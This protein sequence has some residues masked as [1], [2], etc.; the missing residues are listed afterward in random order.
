M[1][2]SKSQYIKGL[3]CNKALWLLKNKPQLKTPFPEQTQQNFNI[4]YQVG[5]LA[6]E[7]FPSGVEIEFNAKDF[8]QMISKTKQLINENLI[9]DGEEIIYEA[10][11]SEKGVFVMVD[12]LRKNGD[13]WD[14]YEVKASTRVK[15]I[16]LEDIAVQKYALVEL[17]NI[18]NC[19]VVH[20]NS[21]YKRQGELDIE[22]LFTIENVSEEIKSIK[23]VKNELEKIQLML[24]ND[25]PNIDIGSHCFSPYACEFM[26]NCWQDI[27]YPSVFN[28][29][30][31]GAKKFTHYQNNKIAYKD[32][33]AEKLTKIQNIQIDTYLN[34]KTHIDKNIIQEF[35]DEVVYPIN[36]FDFETF[37]NA[38]P[39][40]DNQNPYQ[41]IPFQY[42]LH[43][44][45]KD[46][47]L[48]HK[49]FLGSEFED[50]R[51]DLIKNMLKD[52]TKKGSIIAYNQSFEIGRIKDLAEFNPKNK[53]ELLALNPR[54]LD[55]IVPF[56]QLGYYH[57]DFHGSFSIK[58]VLPAMFPNDDELDYKKLD[59]QDGSMAM[60]TFA[61]LY[62]VKDKS[63]RLTIKKNLLAYCRLDTLAM[64]RIYQK[65]L[66]F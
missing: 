26:D 34:N 48:E 60:D 46:G 47:K 17:L 12:I 43:I 59:I 35:V 8:P 55:L 39:R 65:L 14:I 64:V 58:S 53:K 33:Q 19:F 28:L 52:I 36:F 45:H 25:E 23:E 10:T 54:F 20:I 27:P 4:G 38:V 42:S 44:L 24:K 41:Q 63:E 49:E 7:L 50:P 51:K 6:K 62:L 3:Q 29:Y 11:F 9:N 21:E 18:K 61:N 66:S 57:K 22:Q 32:L 1:N 37:Q 15:G 13:G 30:R 31:I 2:L 5:D 16:Y 40:F 56:R